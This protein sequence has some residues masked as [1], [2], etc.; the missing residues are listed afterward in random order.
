[1]LGD[2][3]ARAKPLYGP[4]GYYSQTPAPQ[5]DAEPGTEEDEDYWYDR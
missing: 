4:G 2:L 3:L 5:R 1:M